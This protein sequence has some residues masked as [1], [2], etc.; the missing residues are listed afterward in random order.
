[1]LSKLEPNAVITDERQRSASL[2]A[3]VQ[4]LG[5]VEQWEGMVWVGK[6]QRVQARL[7]VQRVS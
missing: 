1:L 3:F 7:L 4:A 2:L 5:A 6:G